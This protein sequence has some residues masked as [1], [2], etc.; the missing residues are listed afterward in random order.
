MQQ[1]R[2]VPVGIHPDLVQGRSQLSDDRLGVVSLADPADAAQQVEDEQIGDHRA[3]REAPPFYPGHRAG[4]TFVEFVN[5][6]SFTDAGLSDDADEL[7]LALLER[8]RQAVE[9]GDFALAVDKRPR[10]GRCC[11]GN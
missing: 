10:R 3:V 1:Q 2:T 5:E 7:S 4:E 6:P 8:R 11:F 9:H